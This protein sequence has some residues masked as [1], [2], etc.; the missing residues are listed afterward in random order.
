MNSSRWFA[1]FLTFA[2]ITSAL[3]FSAGLS[4]ALAQCSCGSGD[5]LFSQTIIAI[6][7]DM[8]DW[9]APIADLDNNNC[10]PLTVNDRDYPQ[11]AQT[12]GRDLTQM[13]FTWNSTNYFVYTG[14]AGSSNNQQRFL[15]YADLSNDGKMQT[16]E[17][18]FVAAWTGSNQN[19]SLERYWYRELTA[20]GDSMTDGSGYADGWTLPGTVAGGIGGIGSGR[21]SADASPWSSACRGPSS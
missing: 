12:P 4:P 1:R 16:G 10:D 11:S 8:T 9:G 14:R 20:G 21:G 2:L 5:N 15:Y 13:T 7:G 17:P 18:V 19:V 3:G 6:D